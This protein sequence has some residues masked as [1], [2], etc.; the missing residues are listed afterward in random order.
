MPPTLIGKAFQTAGG[1]PIYFQFNLQT[2]CTQAPPGGRCPRG[3]H[4]C[5]EPG[6]A[7]NHSILHHGDT[8]Q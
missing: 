3:F 2:G 4:V 8:H 1:E 6:C 5:A 7:E